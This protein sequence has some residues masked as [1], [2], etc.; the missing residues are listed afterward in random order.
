MSSSRP[1]KTT[2]TTTTTTI[3]H[4]GGG[5]RSSA[6]TSA[7]SSS[8][9]HKIPVKIT[10]RNGQPYAGDPYETPGSP[11]F[12]RQGSYYETNSNN[13]EFKYLKAS[14]VRRQA[15][16][17]P[18]QNASVGRYPKPFANH[19]KLNLTSQGPHK[20]F[21]LSPSPGASTSTSGKPPSNYRGGDPGP[22]RAVYS[23]DRKSVDVVYHDPNGAPVAPRKGRAKP[24]TPYAMAKYRE[25]PTY[26]DTSNVKPSSSTK[27]R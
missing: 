9:T 13:E 6:S 1:K 2:T 7:A 14:D 8:A 11:P 5:T 17:A 23:D 4:S 21:P 3:S 16:Q 25:S 19:E 18:A 10:D 20:E 26:A 24:S 22:V 15:Q 12:V 27:E